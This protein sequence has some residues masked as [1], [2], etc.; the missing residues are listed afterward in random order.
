VQA[1]GGRV[2]AAIK[3]DRRDQFLFQFRRVRAV[4]DE[5]APFEFFQDA[6][7]GRINCRSPI[8]NC[9]LNRK[10]LT[11]RNLTLRLRVFA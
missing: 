4:G 1:V 11:P 3:R 7:A 6:H 5:A 10:S 8:A 2:E 9:Q